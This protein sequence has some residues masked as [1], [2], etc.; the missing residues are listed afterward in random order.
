MEALNTAMDDYKKKLD[1][2]WKVLDGL[3]GQASEIRVSLESSSEADSSSSSTAAA[4]NPATQDAASA[5]AVVSNE[6]PAAGPAEVN[7][8]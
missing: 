3:Y 5:A 2:A 7:E 4:I 8:V 6:M 1:A